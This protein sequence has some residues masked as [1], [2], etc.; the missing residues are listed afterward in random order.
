MIFQ[1]AF[2]EEDANSILRNVTDADIEDVT[3]LGRIHIRSKISGVVQDI[4]IYRTCELSEMSPS[5][6]KLVSAYEKQIKD[7]KKIFDKYKIEGANWKLEP[8]YKLEPT[9]KL[10]KCPNSVLIEFYIKM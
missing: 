10:K 3:D 1:N 6:R 9:G 8:D 4:K 7:D 2:E 5:L